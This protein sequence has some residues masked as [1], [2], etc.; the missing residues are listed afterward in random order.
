MVTRSL[1]TMPGKGMRKAA[2]RSM[3]ESGNDPTEVRATRYYK[4]GGT[5]S[6]RGSLD[7]GLSRHEMPTR[8]RVRNETP[9]STRREGSA[10]EKVE[11]QEGVD[12]AN[13]LSPEGP[14]SKPRPRTLEYQAQEGLNRLRSVCFPPIPLKGLVAQGG[15]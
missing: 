11:I 15:V 14:T 13:G 8:K 7:Q 1:G 12:R 10:R 6:G 3:K 4:P 9:S 2:N 5:R